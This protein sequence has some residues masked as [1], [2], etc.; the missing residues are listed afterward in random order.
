MQTKITER[1]QTV[2]PAEIR[3]RFNLG[4]SSKL[5][6]MVEGEIITVLPLPDNPVKALKGVMKGQISFKKFIKDR[7][8]DREMESLA[9]IINTKALPYK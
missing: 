2:V 8:L 6:W 9:G 1:G 4:K 3:R 7:R 5:L